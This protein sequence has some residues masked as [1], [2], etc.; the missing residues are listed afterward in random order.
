M[1]DYRGYA[2]DICIPYNVSASL[3]KV[4]R[5]RQDF[6]EELYL[7]ITLVGLERPLESSFTPGTY[8]FKATLNTTGGYFELPN[9]MNGEMPGPLLDDGP[10]PHCGQQCPKQWF[11]PIGEL[12][13][14][15]LV[16][17]DLLTKGGL[18]MSAEPLR[19]CVEG[20]DAEQIEIV[21]TC[22]WLFATSSVTG[23]CLAELTQNALAA[24]AFL[25][26]G[27]WFGEGTVI[28]NVGVSAERGAD[29]Q[30][31]LISLTGIVLISVLLGIY[32][33]C[34]LALS[35]YAAW[36]PRWTN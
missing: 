12:E 21:A 14:Q 11:Q 33:A 2:A 25:A 34:M 32:L 23:A 28:D 13:P 24:S 20:A 17:M 22:L 1:T 18:L 31:P 36:T 27:I 3:W 19:P 15:N 26:V 29:M 9:Y 7:N 5:S 16:P 4:Q 35:L 6:S 8:A 30:I 10:E